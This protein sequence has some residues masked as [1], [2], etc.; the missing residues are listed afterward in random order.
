V[1][2]RRTAS[3][4]AA[5]GLAIG[6]SAGLVSLGAVAANAATSSAKAASATSSYVC[7]GSLKSPGTLAGTYSTVLVRGVCLVNSGPAVVTGHVVIAPRGS[8]IAA[9]GR[10]DLTGKGSSNLTIGG[11][12]ILGFRSTLIAGCMAASFSCLD[13]PA[14]GHPTLA[15]STRISGN[16]NAYSALGIVVHNSTLSGNVTQ[17]GGGGGRNCTPTGIFKMVGAPAYT[18]YENSTIGGKLNVKGLRSCWYGTIRDELRGVVR[19][20]GN[21]FADPD[22]MEVVSNRIYRNIFCTRNLPAPQ[23]GDSGGMTNRVHGHGA[24]QCSFRVRVPNPAPDGPLQYLTE[25]WPFPRR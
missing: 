25:R 3:A 20:S 6:T 11:S 23:F 22:A 9:Y 18:D 5:A 10:N 2:I 14:P 7:S 16:V 1:N 13:D 24:G 17:T 21:K 4:L 19:L 12:V 8:L 15:S